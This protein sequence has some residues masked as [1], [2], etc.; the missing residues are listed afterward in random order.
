MTSVTAGYGTT[1]RSTRSLARSLNPAIVTPGIRPGRDGT[2]M[3]QTA[4]A[5]RSG[6]A[7]RMGPWYDA[8]PAVAPARHS[9][10]TQ[11]RAC[12][13][14]GTKHP[15]LQG[16]LLMKHPVDPFLPPP[17]PPPPIPPTH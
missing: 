16:Q 12:G 6:S 1:G 2:A 5:A 14:A 15:D 11:P 7:G 9:S 8:P 4:A 17:Q 10:K 13:D 3:S